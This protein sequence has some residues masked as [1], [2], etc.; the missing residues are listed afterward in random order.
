MCEQSFDETQAMQVPF[1]SQREAIAVKQSLFVK[2]NTQFPDKHFLFIGLRE[3]SISL[4][5]SVQVFEV[6]NDLSSLSQSEFKLQSTHMLATQFV[7]PVNPPGI[8]E[9]SL[10]VAQDT[11]ARAVVLHFD[12]KAVLQSVLLLHKTQF[13]K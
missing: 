2:Q 10:S 4:V 9:H 1:P 13:P 5:Q 8:C 6:H 7:N 3:Q 11:Q 12:N